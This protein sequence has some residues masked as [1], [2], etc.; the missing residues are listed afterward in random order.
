M[1]TNVR[2]AYLGEEHG[3]TVDLERREN[4]GGV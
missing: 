1:I 3:Y 2:L 4:G